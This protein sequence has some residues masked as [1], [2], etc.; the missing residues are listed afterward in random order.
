MFLES[1]ALLLASSIVQSHELITICFS[2]PVFFFGFVVSS[3]EPEVFKEDN[4]SKLSDEN[5][6]DEESVAGSIEFNTEGSR[7]WCGRG[8]SS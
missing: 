3:L 4:K 5:A 6:D 8:G 1:F 2:L 7:C